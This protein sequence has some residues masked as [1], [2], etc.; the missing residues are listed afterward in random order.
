MNSAGTRRAVEEPRPGI[1][2]LSGVGP[3]HSVRSLLWL[4]LLLAPAAL[5]CGGQSAGQQISKYSLEGSQGSRNSMPGA[6]QNFGGNGGDPVLEERR[7]R[8]LNAALHKSMVS[9]TEKLLK[10]V[11]ELNAEIGSTSPA[12]LTPE[13]LRKVAEIEKLAHSIKDKMSTSVRGAPGL[14]DDSSP[15]SFPPTHN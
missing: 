6:D 9:D 15:I 14:R 4:A 12:S 7:L 1:A 11:T 13:Q 5:L 2:R 10:M 8:G 3:R